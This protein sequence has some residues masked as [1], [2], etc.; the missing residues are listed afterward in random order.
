MARVVI[1]DDDQDL[2]RLLERRLVR[3]GHD[4]VTAADGIEGLALIREYQPDLVVLD[5]MMPR[6]NGIEVT[7]LLRD[8]PDSGGEGVRILILTARSQES[9]VVRALSAGADDYLVKPFSSTELAARVSSLL[10]RR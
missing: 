10:A 4:V 5:W 9:D 1:V 2:R 3:E 6:M 8:N 7:Q